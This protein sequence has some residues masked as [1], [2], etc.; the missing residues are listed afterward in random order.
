MNAALRESLYDLYEQ[1]GLELMAHG[2]HGLK[3][4]LII[5]LE[6]SELDPELS[7]IVRFRIVN[8]WDE[9]DEYDE[10][11]KPSKPLSPGA[12]KVLGIASD[13]LDL[14]RPM[15]DAL[16]DFLDFIDGAELV[17]N[18]L[19]FDLGVLEALVLATLS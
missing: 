6:T 13:R 7:G 1:G 9:D 18:R 3:R 14:S 5:D 8:R 15:Q 16:T 10:W 2:T 19:D 17:G 12:E 11:A 4:E